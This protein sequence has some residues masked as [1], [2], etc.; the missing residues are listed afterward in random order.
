MTN[1]KTN[2]NVRVNVG[3]LKI[4]SETIITK[5]LTDNGNTTK[6]LTGNSTGRSTSKVSMST[7]LST[8]K[9]LTST[10][11]ATKNGK[12]RKKRHDEGKGK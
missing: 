3:K 8:G 7:Y 2:Y 6:K 12:G 4:T 11:N 9:V 5:R 10:D 1:A